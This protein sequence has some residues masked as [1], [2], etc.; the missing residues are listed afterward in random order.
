MG[1]RTAWT[2]LGLF[3]QLEPMVAQRVLP[4]CHVP[5]VITRHPPPGAYRVAQKSRWP[6]GF[7]VS[8]RVQECVSTGK[9]PLLGSEVGRRPWLSARACSRSRG[10]HKGGGSTKHRKLRVSPGLGAHRGGHG[11]TDP[12]PFGSWDPTFQWTVGLVFSYIPCSKWPTP[13]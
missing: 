5:L 4:Q 3:S 2:L 6:G 8:A 11:E 7:C 1:L 12:S 9:R 10:V 13:G